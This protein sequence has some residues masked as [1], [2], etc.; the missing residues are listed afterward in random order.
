[1][2]KFKFVFLS[3]AT[4]LTL[5]ACSDGT[6]TDSGT[7]STQQ[8]EE[9]IQESNGAE[10]DMEHDESGEI[11]EGLEE[12]ENPTYPV[13]SQV[14]IQDGHMAGME[15]ADATIEGAFDT[16][17]YEISYTPTDG[18]DPV[19]NHKWV[20]HEEIQDMQE[21]PF[22]PGDS[23]VL[24]ANH[25]SAMNGATAEI[26]SSEDTTVYMVTYTDTETGD[27]V[28]N[29]KWLSEDELAPAE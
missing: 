15:G 2:S 3:L 14:V 17:A 12:A 22:Q 7:E 19:E 5:S 24:E 16:I 23:V 29:H 13:G 8:S 26:D 10:H 9:V 11:P 28:E 27:T 18:S 21:E 6:E 25:M 4:V 20:V 1:M